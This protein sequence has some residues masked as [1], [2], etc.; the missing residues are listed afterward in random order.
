MYI[1]LVATTNVTWER[2]CFGLAC[3]RASATW[4][5]Q[6]Y[7][8]PSY[9]FHKTVSRSSAELFYIGSL[10]KQLQGDTT[11]GSVGGVFLVRKQA[12]A[13]NVCCKKI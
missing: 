9:L 4:E 12:E 2:A 3:Y 1:F 11:L 10:N 5:L 8:L 13:Q 7:L 6:L